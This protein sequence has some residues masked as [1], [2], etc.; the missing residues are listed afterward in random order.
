[1]EEKKDEV[2][3]K[4]KDKEVKTTSSKEKKSS[5]LPNKNF[6]DIIKKNIIN[7]DNSE[8]KEEIKRPSSQK[9]YSKLQ[10]VNAFKNKQNSKSPPPK[11]IKEDEIFKIRQSFQIS[12]TKL[13]HNQTRERVHSL[14]TSFLKITL[15]GSQR[16]HGIDFKQC[17]SKN[18]ADLPFHF[19]SC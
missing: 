17:F 14:N 5:D 4:A 2:D 11:E 10:A 6:S 12:L 9:I 8:K 19:I 1:M 16:N 13:A 7:N 15:I 18:F 3:E